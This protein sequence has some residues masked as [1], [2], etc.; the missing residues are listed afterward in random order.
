MIIFKPR[1]GEYGSHG[2]ALREAEALVE[3]LRDP[4]RYGEFASKFP[5]GL[6]A[7]HVFDCALISCDEVDGHMEIIVCEC[8]APPEKL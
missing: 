1:K 7:K 8:P 5:K 4:V 2:Q 3:A 6:I